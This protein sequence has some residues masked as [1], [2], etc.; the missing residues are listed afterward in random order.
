[1][2]AIL[3]VLLSVLH[4]TAMQKSKFTTKKTCGTIRL[5]SVINLSNNLWE[6]VKDNYLV[7]ISTR[8]I[9]RESFEKAEYSE[10]NE[11]NLIT[12]KEEIP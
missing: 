10:H 8:S 7:W 12:S 6:N 3:P 11:D 4:H 5:V 9:C 1:M 2:L